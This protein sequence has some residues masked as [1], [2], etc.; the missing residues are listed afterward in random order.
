MTAPV[1]YWPKLFA[2]VVLGVGNY[3]TRGHGSAIGYSH[4]F[5]GGGSGDGYGYGNG[6]G[7][8]YGNGNGNDYGK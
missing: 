8:G 2:G 5:R 3:T 6:R 7:Y 1:L 4:V